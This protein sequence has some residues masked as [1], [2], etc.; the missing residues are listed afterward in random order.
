MPVTELG[1]NH[2]Q[3]MLKTVVTKEKQ[4]DMS[5]VIKLYEGKNLWKK[6]RGFENM[7]IFLL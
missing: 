4:A 5:N 6:I 7:R 2:F 1:L 3:G